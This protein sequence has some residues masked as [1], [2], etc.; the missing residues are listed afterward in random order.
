MAKEFDNIHYSFREIDGYNKAFNFVIS[1]RELG[2]TTTMW[3]KKIYLPWKVDKKPWIYLVR[4]SVE[5]SE[6]LIDSIADTI[7]NKF[8]DDGVVLEYKTTTFEKGIVDVKIKGELF[9]RIVALSIKMRR[10]KLATLKNIKGVF[11]DEYVINPQMN[12]RYIPKEAEK[13]KEAYTTWRGECDGLLKFYIVGNPYSLF[14]PLYVDWNVDVNKLKVGEFYIGKTFII[15]YPA[16]SPELYAW[17]LKQNPLYTYDDY[18]KQY[19]LDGK[20]TNDSNIRLGNQP[21]NFSLRFVFRFNRKILGIFSA[22]DYNEDTKFY[23]E[24]ISE[25][26]ASRVSYCFDFEELVERTI[27]VSLDERLKFQRFKEAFRKRLVVFHD[28]NCYYYIEEIYKQL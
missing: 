21:K 8:T 26:S 2:K 16:L 18:Y 3:L 24:E 6:A 14:N 10:I 28:I 7:L 12:E 13:I 15:H 1:P 20:A 25:F 5:I 23:V 4:N 19:A 27:V 9:F 22:N 17:L 11:M